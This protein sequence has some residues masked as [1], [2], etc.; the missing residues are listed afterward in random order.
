MTERSQHRT[1]VVVTRR[2]SVAESVLLIELARPEG[3][4]LPAWAPGAHIELDLA[5]QWKRQ[6]SLCGD[7]AD[8]SRWQIAVLEEPDSRGGSRHIHRQLACGDEIVVRDPVNR[9]EFVEAPRYLFIGGGIGI[10]PLIPMMATAEQAGADWSLVYGGRSLDSMSFVD[11]LR[12]TYRDNV[13]IVPQ[14]RDG[15]LDIEQLLSRRRTG[16]HV[17]CCG[18]D[19]LLNAVE[20][21]YNKRGFPEDELHMERF[22]GTSNSLDDDDQPFLVTI[23]STGEQIKIGP[24]CSILGALSKSGYE[25]ESSCEEG[26]CGSCEVGVLDGVPDHRDSVLSKNEREAGDTIIVCVSRSA[27][28]TLTLDL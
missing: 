16:E 22:R 24:Q 19:G 3:G 14:D 11:S 10:T 20:A 17:Y 25:V 4:T 8:L 9:F 2:E 15:F 21:A 5:G 7:P 6:Y 18:P 23:A 12:E 26:T 13:R 27:G 28:N 1:T